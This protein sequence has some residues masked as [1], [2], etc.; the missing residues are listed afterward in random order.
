MT[1]RGPGTRRSRPSTWGLVVFLALA[2]P[3]VM[4]AAFARDG[5][6]HEETRILQE[7]SA[8]AVALLSSSLQTSQASL[9]IVG[10]LAAAQDYR[11]FEQSAGLLLQMGGPGSNLGTA[12]LQDGAFVITAA[13]GGPAVGDRLTGERAEL[14]ARALSAKQLVAAVIDGVAGAPDV[15]TMVVVPLPS[16]TPMVVFQEGMW[17]STR[18][19][20]P[21]PNSPFRELRGAVY[22]AP[23]PDPAKLILTTEDRLPMKGHVE[24]VKFPVGADEWTLVVAARGSL[25]GDFA[26]WAPWI[27]LGVGLLA[28]ALAAAAVETQTRRGAFAQATVDVRTAEL[29]D[30]RHFLERLFAAGPTAVLRLDAGAGDGE[31]AYVSPNVERVLGVDLEEI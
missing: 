21:T 27:L 11:A 15:K 16:R 29:E 12:T 30:T 9:S 5:V 8:E 4:G 3:T 13:V 26:Q 14:A 19:M 10:T 20:P 23:E 2:G 28:A 18:K 1:R 31:V 6:Q 22:A 17:T 7:R 24:Q 25:V